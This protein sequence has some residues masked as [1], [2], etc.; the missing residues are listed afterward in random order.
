MS[1]SQ[2]AMLAKKTIEAAWLTGPS[3]DLATQAAEA[4]ESAQLLQPPSAEP[5]AQEKSSR[6][7]ADATPA[8]FFRPGRMY[9][10]DLP[11]RTPE[12]RPTFECVG[13]GRH[14]SK[15]GALRAFGFEQ[16]GVGHPWASASQRTEEWVEG[17]V[18][19]GP[20]KPDRLTRTFAPTQVLRDAD[21]AAAPDGDA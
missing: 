6:T 21:Q 20:T 9:T 8:G 5:E 4:L 2:L 7:T 18:D 16:P 14:P 3:Y 15:G 12:D 10:R 19:L 17:W 1:L 13:V 11:F